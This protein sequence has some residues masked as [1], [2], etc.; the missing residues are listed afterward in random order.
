MLRVPLRNHGGRYYNAQV[1]H[2][3]KLARSRSRCSH[4][5]WTNSTPPTTREWAL[6]KSSLQC[7]IMDHVIYIQFPLGPPN[8]NPNPQYTTSPPS[9]QFLFSNIANKRYIRSI[10]TALPPRY[11]HAIGHLSVSRDDGMFIV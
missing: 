10:N 2:I 11:L 7:Y 5:S 9:T 3:E 6:W 8:S 1:T 4:L